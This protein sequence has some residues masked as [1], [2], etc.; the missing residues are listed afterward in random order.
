MKRLLF[1]TILLLSACGGINAPPEIPTGPTALIDSS[2]PTVASAPIAAKQASSGIEVSAD[3][4]WRDG[5]QVNVNVCFSLL[6]ASDWSISNATLQ[7][8]GIAQTEFGTTLASVQEPTPNQKGQ[9]CDTVS[10]FNV[11]PDADLSAATLTV[12]AIAAPP[13]AEDYCT[14][15]MPKIQQSLNDRGIAI[16]LG[17]ND[18]NGGQAM[19]ILGKPENMSQEEAELLVY[20]DEFYSIKGPWTFTFN[21]GQ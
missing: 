15:Y 19:Q 13:R 1:L 18:V 11:P 2:Y 5:K 7:Y 16:T 21:L 17:C 3:Q 8:A 20:S 10:F 14:I 6:D 4:A 9:R 12:D